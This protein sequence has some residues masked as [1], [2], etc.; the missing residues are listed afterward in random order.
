MFAKNYTCNGL[1]EEQIFSVN[2]YYT[3][4]FNFGHGFCDSLSI[5]FTKAPASP[6]EKFLK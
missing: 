2:A 1:Q 3:Y 4:F 6:S 5:L